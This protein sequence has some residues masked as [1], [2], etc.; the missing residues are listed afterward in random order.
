MRKK[1]F[2]ST[3]GLSRKTFEDVFDVSIRVVP[4]ELG[5]LDKAHDVGRSLAGTLGSGE[6]PVISAKGY[7][8]DPVLDVIIVDRQIAILKVAGQRRP[9]AEA[10]VDRLSCGGAIWHL[11]ALSSE[12]LAQGFRRGLG[13]LLT[14]GS[15]AI[16]VEFV[17]ARFALDL[18]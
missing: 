11:T 1:F 12:P 6:E 9:A 16:G 2:E 5:G 7:R 10:I 13:S 4:V 15:P 8:S 3:G 18:I 17:L 14:Q